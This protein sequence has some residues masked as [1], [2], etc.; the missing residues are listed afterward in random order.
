MKKSVDKGFRARSAFKLLQIFDKYPQIIKTVSNPE[1]AIVDLGAAPG[2]WSQILSIYKNPSSKIVAIDLLPI[3]PLDGVNFIK[4]DFTAASAV[5]ILNENLNNSNSGHNH[6]LKLIVSDLCANLSGNSCVDN[7]RNFW[8]WNCALEFAV[9]NLT[10]K[11]HFILK[12]FESSEAN[13][14]RKFLE[15]NFESV[16]V[17]KPKASRA[18]SSEKYFVCLFKKNKNEV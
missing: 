11:G 4:M 1:S 13:Q 17:F 14:F 16:S 9:S 7:Q 15:P 18:E 12:Y 8:L 5:N 10:V 6:V 2:S 3:M